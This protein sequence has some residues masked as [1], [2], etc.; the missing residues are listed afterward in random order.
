[1]D[2]EDRLKYLKLL[3]KNSNGEITDQIRQEIIEITRDRQGN[4]ASDLKKSA[5]TLVGTSQ[6][7]QGLSSIQVPDVVR[8]KIDETMTS[9]L[10]PIKLSFNQEI[11]KYVDSISNDIIINR[12]VPRTVNKS[13]VI[14]IQN[15]EFVKAF[16]D[17]SPQETVINPEFKQLLV[18]GYK[19]T[20]IQEYE[21]ALREENPN[22]FSENVNE[23]SVQETDPLV[24]FF[25][26]IR[27]PLIG[28][29]ES[30]FLKNY[31]GGD[32]PGTRIE[33]IKTTGKNQAGLFKESFNLLDKEINISSDKNSVIIDISSS[34][35]TNF[36]SRESL[37]SSYS[38][39]VPSWKINYI[40]TGNRYF[41]NVKNNLKYSSN[42]GLLPETSSYRFSGLIPD[43]SLSQAARRRL[44]TLNLGDDVCDTQKNDDVFA[45][46]FINKLDDKIEPNYR[47][48]KSEEK[49]EFSS[50]LREMQV[51]LLDSFVNQIFSSINNNRL[52]E[53]INLSRSET[54]ASQNNFI[55]L[56]LINFIP[57]PNEELLN[58]GKNPH[59]LNLDEIRKIMNSKFTEIGLSVVPNENE[60]QEKNA[61]SES[62]LLGSALLAMRLY[63]I[64]YVLK[65]LIV[66][67][68][69]NYSESIF[70][71]PIIREYASIMAKKE[72]MQMGIY[73]T[74]EKVI[75]ENYNF[76]ISN[77]I[78]KE[79][80]VATLEDDF[81]VVVDKN[82]FKM[83][84][85]Q[86]K[87][88]INSML[89]KVIGYMKNLIG[90]NRNFVD[91]D[92]FLTNK[93]YDVF[94]Y[95]NL[96][97]EPE[98]RNSYLDTKR[99]SDFNNYNQFLMLEKYI[100]TP[101]FKNTISTPQN[102]N[103][104]KM[105]EDFGCNL[106][107]GN[108][109]SLLEYSKFLGSLINDPTNTVKITNLKQLK[110]LFDLNSSKVS[111]IGTRLVFT[112][113]QDRFR[114]TPTNTQLDSSVAEQLGRSVTNEIAQTLN[115]SLTNSQISNFS[116]TLNNNSTGSQDVSL[117]RTQKI[118][119][120]SA[121]LVNLEQRR[122][123][124]IK[125]EE[126]KNIWLIRPDGRN[127][128]Y[129]ISLQ[130]P[131]GYSLK[132][133]TPI[134]NR[135]SLQ[136]FN[137]Y[138][139]T[140]GNKTIDAVAVPYPFIKKSSFKVFYLKTWILKNIDQLPL[141]AAQQTQDFNPG[142]DFVK[143]YNFAGATDYGVENLEINT[144]VY[145]SESEK[146]YYVIDSAVG[147]DPP[148]SYI[149]SLE[150][151]IDKLIQE[152]EIYGEY[153]LP[154]QGQ[155]NNI[156][157]FGKEQYSL[158][159]RENK[160]KFYLNSDGSREVKIHEAF[161]RT[162]R[163]YS[164]FDDNNDG[165]DYFNSIDV[166]SHEIIITLDDIFYDSNINLTASEIYF[167]IVEIFENKK[168][169]ILNS[170]KQK[171][172]YQL[173]IKK[174]LGIDRIANLIS[175]HS[176]SALS[177][178]KVENLFKY[179]KKSILE[180]MKIASNIDNYNYK[181][182]HEK[183]GGD[184]A[185]YYR[186]SQNF[187]NPNGNPNA[188]FDIAKFLITTPILIL[189]GLAQLTD[190][191]IAIASQIVNAAAAGLLFPKL[192]EN[193]EIIGYP[194][195]PFI[196]PTA[197]ASMALLPVNLMPP[198]LGI[199]PPVTPLGIYFWILEPLL[200]SFSP[201]VQK[202]FSK[203]EDAQQISNNPKYKGFKIGGNF[204]CDKDQ[205]DI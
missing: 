182:E 119:L 48:L 54:F 106:N 110:N 35:K 66:F 98:K 36:G 69:F 16:P 56:N 92:L 27:E 13:E 32:N 19:P 141:D 115:N 176:T 158:I 11:E 137:I 202:M 90:L 101:K 70:N 18:G 205:D 178:E 41:L 146:R 163:L 51:E 33:N 3:V 24:S 14:K 75:G 9:V 10:N 116:Q 105:I 20:D 109:T 169:Q 189:K 52:L 171:E 161:C 5:N 8:Q 124:E 44:S 79:Q 113:K 65:N 167:R 43:S 22:L 78:I 159:I 76:L 53:K 199:G 30:D 188:S 135:D 47:K 195:D 117:S 29:P 100:L 139:K 104:R 201:F 156:T 39:S 84:S 149:L 15:G 103:F 74:V 88:V 166:A 97:E 172:D 136:K 174:S 147:T 155:N 99:L 144:R 177:N 82:T 123:E 73:E 94:S 87:T 130:K 46:I 120:L 49:R 153:N 196:L 7:L 131:N 175:I 121:E 34:L 72:M 184:T 138:V 40:E 108:V 112:I 143:P 77:N 183:N 191:N 128:N 148:D 71:G 12:N 67:D 203:S 125:I 4:K 55:L 63:T 157:P 134:K 62:V 190:P 111:K 57:E 132:F 91:G 170:L 165:I 64:E 186:D 133:N 60:E 26:G 80:D 38:N 198:G 59:P 102:Q 42:S 61:I 93:I 140:D 25:I 200:W 185:A 164:F 28:T 31:I 193:G 194:G 150:R 21:N 173:I 81:D 6:I 86:F 118:N 122:E 160:N 89:R 187:G 95:N 154:D 83:P 17:A 2:T 181:S 151:E 142:K 96:N 85:L 45:A 68:E 107:G 129:K 126:G 152:R 145:Y 168:S 58:C 127:A 197:V 50:Y 179:T 23:D 204:P 192:N 114:A 1:M 180:I 37:P 162:R